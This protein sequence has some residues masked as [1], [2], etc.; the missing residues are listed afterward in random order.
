MIE[1][2]KLPKRVLTTAESLV[3]LGL[4]HKSS[5]DKL[6]ADGDLIPLRIAREHHFTIDE[7]ERMTAAKVAAEREKR[8][9]QD[10][11]NLD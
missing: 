3:W 8:T 4:D 1:F 7:L 6:V 2:S 9:K 11:T 10:P 5:L